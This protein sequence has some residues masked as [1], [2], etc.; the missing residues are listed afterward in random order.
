MGRH[1]ADEGVEVY[2]TREVVDHLAAGGHR[3]GEL[4]PAGPGLGE[5]IVHGLGDGAKVA[6]AAD[7]AV[8]RTLE[9]RLKLRLH[10][11]VQM[12][13]Q[14][15]IDRK[16]HGLE[17]GGTNVDPEK[18]RP[19]HA[20]S[21][22]RQENWAD[23]CGLEPRQTTRRRRNA[24][25]GLR[26]ARGELYPG[27]PARR[28]GNFAGF[29]TE[30]D[31]YRGGALMKRRSRQLGTVPIFVSAKMGPGTL[32]VPLRYQL[33]RAIVSAPPRRLRRDGRA[34]RAILVRRGLQRQGPTDCRKIGAA[35]SLF[36]HEPAEACHSWTFGNW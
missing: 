27:T 33:H 4:V 29:P 30:V 3:V 22:L 36:F 12:L 10:P 35:G 6:P 8:P 20:E 28:D 32:W 17:R 19:I 26:S 14:V 11:P 2:E 23:T 34:F 1:L 5:E 13:E 21:R 24:S 9:P 16:Q 15:A 25:I 7:L 31:T 18:Q